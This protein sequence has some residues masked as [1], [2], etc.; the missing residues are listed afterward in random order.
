[1]IAEDG[2]K[3]QEIIIRLTSLEWCY[4]CGKT[5]VRHHYRHKHW[6]WP[7]SRQG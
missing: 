3:K 1:L 5:A 2:G 4:S 7:W 6:Q